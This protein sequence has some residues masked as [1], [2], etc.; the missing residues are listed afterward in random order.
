MR[1]GP[2]AEPE[3]VLVMSTLG[4]PERRRARRRRGT[5]VGEAQP[6]A[7]PTS[8]VTVIRPRPFASRAEAADW[9]SRLRA[10]GASQAEIDR[11]VAVLNR[12][13]HAYRAARAD[14]HARDV[15][16]DQA[17]VTRV[18]Y[19]A[20]EAVADG[21]Y[22]EA[23][24]LPGGRR[25]P[26]RRSMEAPDERFAILLGGRDTVLACEELVLRAR[27]D[28]DAGRMREAALQSRV[29][30]ESLLSELGDALEGDRLADLGASRDAV[31]QAANAALRGALSEEQA[32]AVTTAV[33]RMEGALRARRLSRPGASE[34]G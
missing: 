20:G 24:E 16:A 31:A 10:G 8:R 25:E 33:Q 5:V 1:P 18:G 14:P 2:E 6:A 19:G 27:S 21:R 9:L 12:A 7:V 23:L 13:L 34:S 28:V 3:H 26:A 22:E 4:A 17:L 29:A 11:G 30:L 15:S 32:A